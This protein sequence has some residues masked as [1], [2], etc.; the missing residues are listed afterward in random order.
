MGQRKAADS[1]IQ[2]FTLLLSLSV[3]MPSGASL[4]WEAEAVF[5]KAKPGQT[6]AKAEF[7]CR[8]SGE[9]PVTMQRVETSCS[10]TSS[11]LS[12]KVVAAGQ[13]GVVA[14][15]FDFGE[16][17]GRQQKR[18]KVITDNGDQCD[19][20]L[21]VDIP[22]TCVLSQRRLVWNSADLSTQTCRVVNVS[23]EPINIVSVKVVGTSFKACLEEIRPGFEYEVRVTPQGQA[24][25]AV[26]VVLIFTEVLDGG[27]ARTYKVY[28]QK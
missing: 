24:A 20:Y 25:P 27:K 17:E 15:F 9:S 12:N 3:A 5:I 21:N 26:A 1:K 23:E 18:F 6:S 13:T 22:Q 16:R 2:W 10:C 11:V 7:V 28:A 4:V 8:N 14:A 19:L